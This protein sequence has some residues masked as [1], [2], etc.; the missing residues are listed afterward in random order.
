MRFELLSAIAHPTGTRIAEVMAKVDDVAAD[1]WACWAFSN[2]DVMRHATR[3][4]LSPAAQRV[5]MHAADVAC[6]ARS[7]SIRARNWA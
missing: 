7:V 3:W 1:G 4:N 6:A 2:H 5:F